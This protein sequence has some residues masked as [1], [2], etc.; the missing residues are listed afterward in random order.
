MQSQAYYIDGYKPELFFPD[1]TPNIPKTVDIDVVGVEKHV[2]PR[3][4][5]I[6]HVEVLGGVLPDLNL[7]SGEGPHP[8]KFLLRPDHVK[9]FVQTVLE[10][11]VKTD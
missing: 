2:L 4:G 9:I 7:K 8:T 1:R 10:N 6:S 3:C 11:L 5:E